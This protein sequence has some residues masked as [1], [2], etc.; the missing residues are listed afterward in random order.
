MAITAPTSKQLA[1]MS[2]FDYTVKAT[3]PLK[4]F[5]DAVVSAI[6][7]IPNY[8]APVAEPL[9]PARPPAPQP[10]QVATVAAPTV[11]H[12]ANLAA[13]RQHLQELQS[14]E[15]ELLAAEQKLGEMARTVADNEAQLRQAAQE[16]K[17]EWQPKLQAFQREV[18][19]VRAD[20]CC[21]QIGRAHV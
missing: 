11:D 16:F 15:P 13:A 2:G 7:A 12:S 10:V 5:C 1:R 19:E 6:G 3:Q 8:A 14:Q 18:Q 9:P 4:D 20:Q 21:S 17:D